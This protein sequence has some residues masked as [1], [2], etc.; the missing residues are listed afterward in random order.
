MRQYCAEKL[1]AE[2]KRETG[3]TPEQVADRHCAYFSGLADDYEAAVKDAGNPNLAVLMPELDNLHAA[4]Q[5]AIECR[6][7]ESFRQLF[8]L[9]DLNSVL[10][11]YRVSLQILE[12]S[13]KMLK[14][15]WEVEQSSEHAPRLALLLAYLCR[16]R[17]G[18]LNTLDQFSDGLAAADAGLAFLERAE[19]GDSGKSRHFWLRDQQIY[20]DQ[21]S[22][23]SPN[24]ASIG[25]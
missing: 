19:R 4:W 16:G 20:R 12:T 8:P 25:V 14:K 18:H 11:R 7:A 24:R 21:P 5:R 23:G 13:F 1:A 6:D 9:F 17:A 10:G 2:H 15:A 22:G 3:E